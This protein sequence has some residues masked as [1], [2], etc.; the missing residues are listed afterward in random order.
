MMQSGS[1]AAATHRTICAYSS[2][3]LITLHP[4]AG[5][6]ASQSAKLSVAATCTN[7]MSATSSKLVSYRVAE[8]ASHRAVNMGCKRQKRSRVSD[9]FNCSRGALASLS[10]IRGSMYANQTSSSCIFFVSSWSLRGVM[11]GAGADCHPRRHRNP[12]RIS[13]SVS[14]FHPRR[15]GFASGVKT[16][17]CQTS[18]AADARTFFGV[19][20]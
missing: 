16:R 10:P 19:A 13:F 9:G 3:S 15:T 18:R 14:R 11:S 8:M 7:A 5:S 12:S 20:A 2:R 6:L 1:R 4:P 17:V